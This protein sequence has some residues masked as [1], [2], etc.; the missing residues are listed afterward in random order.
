[1]HVWRSTLEGEKPG[2]PL[3]CVQV[4]TAE[5]EAAT[6][7]T[8]LVEGEGPY[9][10]DSE[11][12]MERR[13]SGLMQPAEA[14]VTPRLYEGPK[15]TDSITFVGNRLTQPQLWGLAA[16]IARVLFDLGTLWEQ[17]QHSSDLS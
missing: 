9:T 1:M 6:E 12:V 14:T 16:R 8:T 5:F 4:V 2:D 3:V 7:W 11:M 10:L 17:Q 15:H 13:A